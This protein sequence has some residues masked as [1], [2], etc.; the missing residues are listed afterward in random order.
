MEESGESVA[1]IRPGYRIDC[2]RPCGERGKKIV[3]ARLSS[4]VDVAIA[5]PLVERAFGRAE[6]FPKLGLIRFEAAGMNVL[7]YASGELVFRNVAGI[8]EAVTAADRVVAALEK[9]L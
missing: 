7:L 6:R 5:L 3:E 4:P 9:L 2:I 1:V 8:G